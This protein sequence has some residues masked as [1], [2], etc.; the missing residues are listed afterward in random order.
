MLVLSRT[1]AASLIALTV[2]ALAPSPALADSPTPRPPPAP[3]PPGSGTDEAAALS[4]ARFAIEAATL[5][6][7][8][9]AMRRYVE[10]LIEVLRQ[11]E[12]RLRDDAERVRAQIAATESLF[13]SERERLDALLRAA[14][15]SSR[16]SP[17]ELALERG[18]L[19]EGILRAA[20]F[21]ALGDEERR[22]V[23]SLRQL[24]IELDAQRRRLL[25]DE[26]D[27][28]RVIESQSAKRDALMRL[29]ARARRLVDA[30][31]DGSD[32][33]YLDAELE[34]LGELAA[35]QERAS[36]ELQEAVRRLAPELDGVLARWAWPAAGVVSQPFG[37]SALAIEPPLEYHGV[38]YPHFHTAVD[39]AA[40]LFSPVV[41]AADGVVSYVGRFS[42]GAMVVL[43]SHAEGYVSLY[44]HLDDGLRPPLVRVGDVVRAGQVLGAVGLTGLTTGPHLHFGVLRRGA[45]VDPRS[46]LPGR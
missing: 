21:A 31:R 25:E 20:G 44:A 46:L 15:R 29:E 19:I 14:Y 28:S 27:L 18:S 34:V 17:L 9:E 4:A 10:L 32:R 40:G 43:V 23:E 16:T 30:Q 36:A 1:L 42:D 26:A 41:A 5:R 3:S 22:L 11:R 2:L 12:S 37:P 38:R 35:E 45:P 6:A 7:R 8:I 13:A 24:R 33:R 39:I